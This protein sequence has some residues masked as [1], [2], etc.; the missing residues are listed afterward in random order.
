M[1]VR[2]TACLLGLLVLGL[3]IGIR[4]ADLGTFTFFD[5]PGATNTAPLSI[6]ADGVIV[7]RCKIGG[8]VHG[9]VRTPSGDLT[10]V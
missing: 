4:G 5:V 9:F 1:T 10:I 2:T 6:N 7:G 8:R 3:P